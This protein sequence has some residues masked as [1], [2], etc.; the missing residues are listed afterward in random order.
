MSNAIAPQ[1]VGH[2]LRGF[3]IGRSDA[4]SEEAFGYSAVST[5]L[6]QHIHHIAILIDSSPQAFLPTRY[7]HED[8][9]DEESIAQSI[10]FTSQSPR[11]PRSEFDAPKPD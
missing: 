6:Q 4:S 11:V 2:G 5:I 7:L 1:L 10:A 9:I 8:F 3:R